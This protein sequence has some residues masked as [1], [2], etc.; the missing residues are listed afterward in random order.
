MAVPLSTV[1]VI[2]NGDEVYRRVVQASADSL[3]S[4]GAKAAGYAKRNHP[5]WNNISGNAQRSIDVKEFAT[6][7]HLQ[8]TY[9]STG[10]LYFI[11]LEL[12]HGSA[13]RNA[14]DIHA[15][16]K[17]LAAEMKRRVRLALR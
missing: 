3:N 1:R 13:L 15:N 17:T 8:V 5:G 7:S 14:R 16:E 4:V 2:W 6:P 12:K 10:V 11:W 9:G